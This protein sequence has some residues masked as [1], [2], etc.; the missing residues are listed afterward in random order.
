MTFFLSLALS[1]SVQLNCV[2]IDGDTV[3]FRAETEV[4]MTGSDVSATVGGPQIAVAFEPNHKP[5]NP[6]IKLRTD[7]DAEIAESASQIR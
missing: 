3:C 2:E 5:L 1:Q 7:F 4:D 6:M